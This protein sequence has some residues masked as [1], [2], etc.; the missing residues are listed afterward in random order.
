V[1]KA[2]RLA[3]EA[4]QLRKIEFQQQQLA[5]E[6]HNDQLIQAEQMKQLELIQQQRKM[7]QKKMAGMKPGT[8]V[9]CAF[10]TEMCTQGCNNWF[11]GRLAYAIMRVTNA[12]P[13][14]CSLLLP[15]GTVN[16]VQTLKVH[17]SPKKWM[18]QQLP[19]RGNRGHNLSG[20]STNMVAAERAAQKAAVHAAINGHKQVARVQGAGKTGSTESADQSTGVFVRAYSS[21]AVAH[22]PSLS[23]CFSYCLCLSLLLCL[24]LPLSAEY[25]RH[26]KLTPRGRVRMYTK[27]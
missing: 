23:F 24:P 17:K 11:P 14:G 9:R 8:T 15:G 21:L 18:V 22:L 16:S 26:R 12:T 10:S 27:R 20:M 1:R 19:P 5:A 13:L 6:A 2:N 7:L 4:D 25:N 3:A